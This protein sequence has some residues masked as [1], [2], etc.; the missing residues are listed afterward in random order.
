MNRHQYYI[1]SNKSRIMAEYEVDNAA[2]RESLAQALPTL[3]TTSVDAADPDN[4]QGQAPDDLPHDEEDYRGSRLHFQLLNQTAQAASTGQ[5]PA[6]PFGYP[7]TTSV[8]MLTYLA[9]QYVQTGAPQAPNAQPRMQYPQPTQTVPPSFSYSPQMWFTLNIPAL[10]TPEASRSASQVAPPAVDPVRPTGYQLLDDRI[11][12]IEGFSSFGIDA[13]DLC[14]VPNVVLPQKFKVPDLPKYKGLS[15]PR[16]H[17]TMYC[18]KMAS[19][20][21]NDNLLIH[22]FQDSLAG[23][24]LDWYMSLE[25]SKIRSWRDLFEA[26]LKQYKYNLDMAPTRLQLQNQWQRSNETFKEYAQRWREM[27]FRV[28]PALSDNE[29]V[30]IFM[31]TLQG[32]YFEKMINSSSKKFVDTV[33]IREHVESGLKSR[34]ITDTTAQQTANKRPHRGFSKKKEGEANDVMAKARP[35]YQFL[36]APMPYDPY[37]YI[38]AAQYQ[39]PPFC[40]ASVN[41]VIEEESAKVILKVEEVKTQMSIILQR[42]EQFGFLE[43]VH[44]DCTVCEFDLDNCEQLKGCVQEL[45]DQGLIHFSKS[46]AAEEVA[47]IEPITINTKAVPWNHETTEYLGGKEICIPD[48]EI[49]NITG[50][51]GMTRSVRVFAPKYTPR[52]SPAPIVISP[53]EKVTPTPTPQAGATVLATPTMTTAP[54]LTKVIDNNKV[55]EAEASKGKEPMIEKEQFEDH[56]KSITFEESQ[57]FLKL[58]KKSDFKI[59]DQLNQT[60][61]KISILSLLLS[62]ET[63]RKALLKV[64]N[65]AHVIQDITV[66]QFDDVVANITASRYL[67]FNK[68]E[69]PPEG[70]AHNKALHISVTCTD[71]LLSRVLVDTGSSLI[72]LPKSTLS[73]LQFK[74]TEMR[75][76]ALIVRAFDGSRRQVIGEVDFPICVGPHQF[77]ITFQVMDINPAYSCLLGRPQIHAA[78]EVTSTLHQK[79]KYLIDDKLVIVCGEEDLLV[80]ELSSFRY[81]ET[82]EGIVEVPLHCLEFEDVSS[83]TSNSN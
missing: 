77:D 68:A 63:H 32:L 23:A 15:C 65:T 11:R 12:V 21:D 27:A 83:V 70:K 53:K 46:Q 22:C 54:V 8:P 66:D 72:M 78:G 2:N 31:G 59:I 73:Q 30:D 3:Q 47:V 50:A 39:Q 1:R 52:V 9:S 69:L 42:L 49:V 16:N 57:E 71:S 43:G 45:M 14:L 35:R 29:L 67:G 6:F 13:R 25:R 38:A 10:I 44:D 79:L 26:F 19:H 48:T 18:R 55:V 60:P 34:K 20:I 82:N 58:I 41:A 33:T 36:M 28:R 37:P 5:V 17:L 64:L 75:T 7:G 62:S 80:S 40:G 4:N 51:G 74:G 56:N 81:V 24:S 76:S 61:S